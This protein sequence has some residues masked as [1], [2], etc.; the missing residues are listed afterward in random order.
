MLRCITSDT[1]VCVQC[2]VHMMPGYFFTIDNNNNFI[3]G[4]GGTNFR[5]FVFFYHHPMIRILL[6]WACILCSLDVTICVFF[7]F[8]SV[9]IAIFFDTFFLFIHLLTPE[10]QSNVNITSNFYYSIRL[11]LF[12]CLVF[13]CLFHF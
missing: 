8:E 7:S 5:M 3:C 2:T 1:I 9:F 6:Y 10:M 12:I 4:K 13:V 11:L